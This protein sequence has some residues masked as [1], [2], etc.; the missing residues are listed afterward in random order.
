MK[1]RYFLDYLLLSFY[2]F[3]L[4]KSIKIQID[5]LILKNSFSSSFNNVLYSDVLDNNILDNNILDNKTYVLLSINL[6]LFAQPRI[7]N[8]KS[9]AY[10]HII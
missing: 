10:F 7:P 8:A 6:S 9:I 3:Y 5:L 4:S 1:Y 2:L